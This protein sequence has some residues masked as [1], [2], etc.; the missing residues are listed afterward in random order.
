MEH[1][2]LPAMS[3]RADAKAPPS[4]YAICEAV[5]RRHAGGSVRRARDGY[6]PRD[7]PSHKHRICRGTRSLPLRS[8]MP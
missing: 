5:G 1:K 7:S 3:H 4:L 8:R 6:A 2:L